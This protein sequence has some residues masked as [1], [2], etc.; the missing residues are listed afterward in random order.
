MMNEINGLVWPAAGGIGSIPKDTWDQTV[1]IAKAAGIISKDPVGA[2]RS[3]LAD[4]ARA[5]VTGDVIGADFKP[6]VVAITAGASRTHPHAVG[7]TATRT[8]RPAQRAGLAIPGAR[9]RPSTEPN[10]SSTG[11]PSTGADGDGP[12]TC[13][14]LACGP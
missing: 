13:Q 14:M 12:S 9:P 4:A 5:T 3:D 1:K 10:R 8:P 7:L 2:S 11:R 6:G